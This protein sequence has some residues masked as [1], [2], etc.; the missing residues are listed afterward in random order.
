[1]QKI[2][3]AHGVG[4][5][6]AVEEMILQGRIT[7]NRKPAVIGARAGD[8]DTIMLDGKPLARRVVTKRLICYHKPVG[9][10]VEHGAP[11]SVFADLPSAN[12]GRW[13]N[14]G[15]LDVN[16]EGLLLFC[17]DGETAHRLAHPS[18]AEPREYL[19]RVDGE[20]SD[21]Q[22]RQI[23]RGIILDGRRLR[24]SQFALH[25]DGSGRNHWYRTVLSEGRNRAVR[26]LFAHF[27]LQTARL[28]RVRMAG[29][30]LPRDLPPGKW[31]EMPPPTNA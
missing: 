28:I 18:F 6:R 3:A 27:G 17:T 21:D 4:S 30:Q 26:K 29:Y 22:I 10:I 2:L 19:A 25:R 15:R 16:S 8:K 11:N 14:I 31:R 23:R 9:K 24:P 20:L 5:R 1:M 7:V 13:V 12:G